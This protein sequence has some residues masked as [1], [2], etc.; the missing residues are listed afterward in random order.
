MKK[1][2]FDSVWDALEG[3]SV[4]VENMKLR[5]KLLMAVSEKIK[6]DGYTQKKAAKLLDVTQPRISALLN[7]KIEEF[8]IDALINMLLRLGY[9]VEMDVAA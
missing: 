2:K 3:D 6:A 5:S 1:Q 7:G 8:R 4:E 9:H